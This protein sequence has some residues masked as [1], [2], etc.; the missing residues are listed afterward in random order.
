MPSLKDKVEASGLSFDE[1]FDSDPEV[2]L[3]ALCGD[4]SYFDT[5]EGVTVPST[6]LEEAEPKGSL[7]PIWCEENGAL[8][9]NSAEWSFGNG[10]TGNT[11]GIPVAVDCEL[12]AVSFNVEFFGTSAE[13]IIQRNVVTVYTSTHTANNTV[14]DLVTPVLFSKGDLVVF[15]TGA[16]TGTFTDGRICAWFREV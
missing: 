2:L 13:A 12:V 9:A 14:N 4:T 7:F 11:I 5:L 16:L 3:R 6:L 10:A 8:N 1:I 15:R